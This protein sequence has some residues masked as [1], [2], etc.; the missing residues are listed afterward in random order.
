MEILFELLAQ[1]VLEIF[2][3]GIFELGGRG[4]VAIF[5]KDSA[6]NPWLAICGYLVMG[7]ISGAISVWVFPM[8][9]LASPVMQI[10]N[11]AITPIVLGFIFEAMGRWRSN[12]DK[13]RYS[14]DRFSYGFT[15]ALTM[16]LI[17]YFFAA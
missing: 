6:T 11:L 4:I 8:H 9:L 13:P 2:V 3:Q 7:A 12:Q 14:V 10:L 16:G 1:L 17:R 5:R 15:F